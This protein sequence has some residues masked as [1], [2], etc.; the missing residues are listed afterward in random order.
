MVTDYDCWKAS[1]ESVSVEMVMATMK[2]NTTALRRML[3]DIVTALKGRNDCASR[4]AAASAIMTEP[5]LI[6]HETRRRLALLYGKYWG[7]G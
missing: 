2:A 5:S 4:Y 6:P 7:R 1:E 3:P